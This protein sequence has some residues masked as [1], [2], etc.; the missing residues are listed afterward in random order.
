M[1]L[2]AVYQERLDALT[3][4]HEIRGSLAT[5]AADPTGV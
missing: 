4:L 5:D 2:G 1:W 3:R